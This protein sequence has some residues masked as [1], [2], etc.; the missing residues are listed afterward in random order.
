MKYKQFV[1]ESLQKV[2]KIA[3]AQF[4]K[5]T[6]TTKAEDNNQV[7]TE[8]DLEIAFGWL[9]QVPLVHQTHQCFH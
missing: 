4:G 9:F 2:S 3:N 6:A 8:T 5:V 1:N 7:L